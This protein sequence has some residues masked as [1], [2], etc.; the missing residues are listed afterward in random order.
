MA[1]LCDRTVALL[2]RVWTSWYNPLYVWSLCRVHLH[3]DVLLPFSRWSLFHL[4]YVL[5][6]V[7]AETLKLNY[8]KTFETLKKL[9]Q[10]KTFVN[11]E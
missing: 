11:V 3:E 4:R 1:E 10:N 8:K 9:D 5:I 6:I 7:D 2:N